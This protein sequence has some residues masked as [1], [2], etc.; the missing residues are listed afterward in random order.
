VDK[1]FVALWIVDIYFSGTVFLFMD[2]NE[3]QKATKIGLVSAC[4]T[5]VLSMFIY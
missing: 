5:Y 3:S 1:H 2:R 4:F